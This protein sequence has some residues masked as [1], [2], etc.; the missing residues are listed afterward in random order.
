M[1]VAFRLYRRKKVYYCQDN[2]SGQQQSLH[3]T[4]K[5]EATRVLNA[6]NEAAHVGTISLQIAS[7]YMG[8]VD[9]LMA[10]RTWGDVVDFIIGQHKPGPTR[11]RWENAKH[12]KSLKELW[13][14]KVAQTRPDQL[15]SIVKDGT[16][17]TNV[18][19]RR[20]HNFAFD[21]KWLA[22]PILGRRQWPKVVYR[23]KRGITEAEHL[24]IVAREP[25]PER[26]D[27]YELLWELGGSQTDIAWLHAEDVN[28]KDRTIFYRRRKNGE[29]AMPQFGDRAA[30]ILTR[31]PKSGP[32][33]PYL[34]KVREADRATEFKQRCDGLGI[35]GVTLHSYRYAWAERAAT[36]GYPE[37]HAQTNLGHRSK[38]FAHAYAKKAKVRTPALEV[39][40]RAHRNGAS[41]IACIPPDVDVEAER[42]L[43]AQVHSLNGGSQPVAAPA[44]S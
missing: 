2:E 41:K 15:L 37:R 25:N 10:K 42:I 6:K 32:L 34:I 1:K 27:Y 11:T 38:A 35:K 12:D 14:L 31:R 13:A 16:V 30:A 5:T 44:P 3:T 26:R 18:F 23:E 20:L 7:A 8:A 33:F 29:D 22:W 9:P 39:Y 21:M 4:D 36:V 19:L 28:W 24:M 40:E 43:A 17:S